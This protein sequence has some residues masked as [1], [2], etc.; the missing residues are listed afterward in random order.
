MRCGAFQYLAGDDRVLNARDDLDGAAAA[1]TDG[2]IDF[3]NTCQSLGPRHSDVTRERCLL[4]LARCWRLPRTTAAFRRHD[5]RA[6]PMVGS[7]TAVKAR[8]V[9]ARAGDQGGQSRQEIQRFENDVGGAVAVR[10][11]ERVADVALGREREPAACATGSPARSPVRGGR[12]CNINALRPLCW[13][14]RGDRLGLR[15]NLQHSRSRHRR[16][17]YHGHRLPPP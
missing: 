10:G 17:K 11:L 4:P 6:Q 13:A 8:Q 3:K 14:E 2:H 16:W 1:L 12:L 9:D 7:K 15:G 5:L